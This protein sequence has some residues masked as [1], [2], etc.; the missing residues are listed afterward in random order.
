MLKRNRIMYATFVCIVIL[1]GLASRAFPLDWWGDQ[2]IGDVLWALMVFY[3]FATVFHRKDTYW[4]AVVAIGF[5]FAIEISQLYQGDWINS[6]R[7]TRVG[8]LILGYG[9]LWSDLVAYIVGVSI[10]AISDRY[11][12]KSEG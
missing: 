12:Y 3:L 7:Y 6:I 9:F 4:I 2:Y 11:L 8:G 5:A 10:G 1:L